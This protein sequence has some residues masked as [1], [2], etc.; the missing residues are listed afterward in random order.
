MLSA[1]ERAKRI[2]TT[3]T[4]FAP[5]YSKLDDDFDLW[6]LKET[7]YEKY[8]TAINVT[9]NEPRLFADD[10]QTDLA[11]SEMQIIV[12]MAE[13]VGKDMGEDTGKLERLFHFLLEK[14]DER[15]IAMLLPPLRETLIWFSAIRGCLAARILNYIDK[16]G[17][18]ADYLPL[19]PRWLTYEV[20]EKM[21]SWSA[22][23]LFKTKQALEDMGHKPK[24][25]PFYNFWTKE[26]DVYP[27]HDYWGWEDGKIVN[28]VL[29][30]SNEVKAPVYYDLKS[31]P[32][33]IMPVSA[34][35]P[36]VTEGTELGRYGES[37]YANKRAMYA[38][39]NKV[40]TMHATH[41][42]ILAKQPL[43]NYIDDNDLRIETTTMYAEGIVN[44]KMGHQRIEPSPMREVSPTLLNLVNWVEDKI[45]RGS[46]PNPRLGSPPPSGT[47]LNLY[48][49]WGNKIYNP[50]VRILGRFYAGILRLTEGQ[51]LMGGVGGK[52]ITKVEIKTE[53]DRK[54]Y[55]V[56]VKPIDLKKPHIINVEFTVKTA[57]SQLD[58][59]SLSDMLIRQGLP[60]RWVWEFILKVP[61]PKLLEELAIIEM[62]ENSP[63]LAMKKAVEVL[64]KYERVDDAKSLVRDM[65]RMEAMEEQEVRSGREME[66][67]PGGGGA[68]EEMMP[69]PMV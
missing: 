34:R 68:G 37:I 27:V 62:V 50:Q 29:Y 66:A 1:D 52:K 58:V 53:K 67:P 48:R 32:T 6:D 22:Y 8:E 65:D 61:D 13:A 12:R 40:N 60:K 64:M 44:L 38:L 41:A 43:L 63:K 21:L 42:N 16:D 7:K 19:D 23:K 49:E 15:L 56:D 14:A 45:E 17:L 54:L 20:G 4:K 51:L 25:V 55:A 69:P 2:K 5:Y 47:A 46:T 30:E 24:G 9:S 33:L 57:Y 28:S 36:V 10:V 3:E 39:S 11:F 35:P 18:V 59:A 31:I 26:R